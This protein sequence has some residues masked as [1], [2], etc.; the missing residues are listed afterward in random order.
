MGR[1]L[2]ESAG[3]AARVRAVVAEA[4]AVFVELRA[5]ELASHA[6][7]ALE[8]T[9]HFAGR[10]KAFEG[11]VAGQGI[12]FEEWMWNLPN[13]LARVG[14]V[15]TAIAVADAFGALDMANG[16]QY[17]SD[18]ASI[19]A[20]AGRTVE[21]TARIGA[22]IERWPDS[23]WVRIQ[24]GEALQSMGEWEKARSQFV[25]AVELAKRQTDPSAVDTAYESLI[26]FLSEHPG[27][28]HDVKTARKDHRAWQDRTG[29]ISATGDATRSAGP[30]KI[31][32][33]QPCP[34][35]SG[36]KYKHCCGQNVR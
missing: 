9:A 12:E 21:A 28:K 13:A 4:G 3:L 11:F 6:G 32:R 31:G 22:N 17:A 14:L 27:E 33:N 7:L 23:P 10:P 16:S 2:S 8:L 15:D 36:R 29:W 18:A 26:Q 1:V 5:D 20:G 34:C 25:Q 30:A 24:T 19:L 35:G